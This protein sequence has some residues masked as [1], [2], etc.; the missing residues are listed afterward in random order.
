MNPGIKTTEKNV[1]IVFLPLVIV[2]S[3]GWI[4]VWV[5]L[6]GD[7]SSLGLWHKALTVATPFCIVL[8]DM[9]CLSKREKRP[10]F[11]PW[12]EI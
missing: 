1:R 8:A 2:I 7:V 5:S 4:P 10:D 6:G 9:F 12:D 11:N 3:I